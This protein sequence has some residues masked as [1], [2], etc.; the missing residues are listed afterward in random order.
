MPLRLLS[1]SDPSQLFPT[2]VRS[3]ALASCNACSRLGGFLAPYCTVYLVASGRTHSAVLL[4][5][6]LCAA[7][8]LAALLLPY[9]TAGCDL[10]AGGPGGGPGSGPG[11]GSGGS[12]PHTRVRVLHESE[13]LELEPSH[14]QPHT[15][16]AAGP[17]LPPAR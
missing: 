9:E 1:S 2:H 4:L 16:S 10:G 7:A 5:G 14:E 17:L 15:H 3:I 13:E 12:S 11:S 6:S 8:F